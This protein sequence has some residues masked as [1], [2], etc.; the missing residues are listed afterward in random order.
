MRSRRSNF[1]LILILLSTISIGCHANKVTPK[2]PEAV[3]QRMNRDQWAGFNA[4]VQIARLEREKGDPHHVYDAV[5]H[6][7]GML[8]R[9]WP[10]VFDE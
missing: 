5:M 6:W 1:C 7:G 9:C 4:L 2:P 10:E 3:C 8:R